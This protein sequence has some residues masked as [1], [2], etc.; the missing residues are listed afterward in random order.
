MN[1]VK[2]SVMLKETEDQC[3]FLV[4]MTKE[5]KY[6]HQTDQQYHKLRSVRADKQY[7]N[8]RAVSPSRVQNRDRP[9]LEC[10]DQAALEVWD[11]SF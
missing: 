4:F 11:L 2:I 9:E 5:S 10:F 8:R 3:L 7:Q 1:Y 6:E